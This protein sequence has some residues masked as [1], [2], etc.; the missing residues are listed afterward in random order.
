MSSRWLSLIFSAGLLASVSIL[1]AGDAS[2][3]RSL[4]PLGVVHVL[5][6]AAIGSR[7]KVPADRHVVSTLHRAGFLHTLIGLGGAVIAVAGEWRDAEAAMSRT[8]TALAPIGAALVP[9]VL[10]VWLA[11]LVEIR[12]SSADGSE[13][14]A[15]RKLGESVD[16]V[17]AALDRVQSAATEFG[18][19]V[20]SAVRSSADGARRVAD[21]MRAL[22]D[23]ARDSSESA[24][25]FRR[26][27]DDLAVATEQIHLV[28]G[29]ILELVQSE[30][31]R[32]GRE[33]GL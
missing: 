26:S 2:G 33:R 27:I 22:G 31:V 30:L 24:K 28:H 12:R 8:A 23:I 17:L 19:R 21:A 11:H 29:Q 5:L 3:L 20:D 7:V 25:V 4:L 9:H 10:G 13:D 18:S 16:V 15:E 32:R 1:I 6:L 14:D